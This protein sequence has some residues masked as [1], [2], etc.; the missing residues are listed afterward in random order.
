MSSSA[1]LYSWSALPTEQLNPLLTRR[2][3]SGEQSTIAY[4]ELKKGCLVAAHAHHN[5][6][7]SSIVSGALR[8]VFDPDGTPEEITVRAGEIVVI[9][10]HLKHSAEALED[11]VNIDF[12]SPA[13]LDWVNGEDAY[14]RIPQK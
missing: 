13:R 8:F 10:A 6:Q 4:L 7:I 3:V 12:F 5:E 9:P 2:F 14:L 1:K 11:T